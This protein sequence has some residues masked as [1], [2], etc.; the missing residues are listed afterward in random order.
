MLLESLSYCFRNII[1]T[2]DISYV[3]DLNLPLLFNVARVSC[4]LFSLLSYVIVDVLCWRPITIALFLYQTYFIEQIHIAPAIDKTSYYANG[5]SSRGI[6]KL[7][8]VDLFASLQNNVITSMSFP[9]NT[10]LMPYELYRTSFAIFCS[11]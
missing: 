8:H 6:E 5:I 1:V 7:L 3:W 9:Q 4:S 10:A 11:M 2:P